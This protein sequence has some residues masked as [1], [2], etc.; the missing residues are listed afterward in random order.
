M[1]LQGCNAVAVINCCDAVV[2]VYVT[3]MKDAYSN[4][5]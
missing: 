1:L 2:I 4:V 3:L 5:N